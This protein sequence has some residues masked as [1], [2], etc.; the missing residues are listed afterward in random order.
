MNNFNDFKK[1]LS[2]GNEI[3]FSLQG[4][5]YSITYGINGNGKKYISFCEFYKPDTEFAS[6]KDFM[7]N[8]SINGKL[9]S[10]LWNLAEDIEIY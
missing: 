4:R 9:L 5:Q 3:E 2:I 6:T 1:W 10:E 7:Q 8:A